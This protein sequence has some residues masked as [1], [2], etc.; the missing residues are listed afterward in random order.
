MLTSV[1]VNA[2]GFEALQWQL[3]AAL[4]VC[5]PMSNATSCGK[6]EKC[7]SFHPAQPY[8]QLFPIQSVPHTASVCTCVCARLSEYV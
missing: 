6:A 5:L 3:A 8:K 4:Y 7:N 2:I 1:W